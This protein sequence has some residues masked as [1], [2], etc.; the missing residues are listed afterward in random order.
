MMSSAAISLSAIQWAR[1]ATA[2]VIGH[3]MG[4]AAG[5]R[6]G[7]ITSVLEG[8][9]TSA[10]ASEAG[11]RVSILRE[12]KASYSPTELCLQKRVNSYLRYYV[13]ECSSATRGIDVLIHT[14]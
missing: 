14:C 8:T 2:P 9:T 1:S 3:R 5:M 4:V 6:I 11:E 13:L 7:W 10:A 12:E